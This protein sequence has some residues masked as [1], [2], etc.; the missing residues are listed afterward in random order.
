MRAG[1]CSETNTKRDQ[2]TPRVTTGSTVKPIRVYYRLWL[3]NEWREVSKRDQRRRHRPLPSQLLAVGVAKG[4]HAKGGQDT[5]QDGDG[6][7]QANGAG[8]GRAAEDD[9]GEEAQLDA[10]GLAVLQAIAADAIWTKRSTI[11]ERG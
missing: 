11:N 3:S 4:K 8:N 6:L 9:G 5:E 1:C 2:T 7:L 10:V